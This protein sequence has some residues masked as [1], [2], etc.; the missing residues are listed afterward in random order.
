L[1]SIGSVARVIAFG[2]LLALAV[3]TPVFSQ[4]AFALDTVV[5]QAK[6]RAQLLQD[7]PAAIST[8]TAK[9]L[10]VAGINDVDDVAEHVPV[11]DLQ[12]S[13]SV[14]T[15]SFRIRRVGNLGNIPTFEPAVG[16]FVDGAF[17]SRSFLAGDLLNV[18]RVEV[19]SGPQ[20]TLYGKNASA[21]VVAI[22]T[23]EPAPEPLVEG[24]LS[25]GLF[26]LE[27]SASVR[28][29]R[30][31][32]SGP[33]SD[34]WR[35]SIAA[36]KSRHGATAT[37][38]M[39]GAP[40]G[41][42]Q[43]RL[44]LRGQLMWSPSSEL[45]LRLIAGYVEERDNQGQPDVYL[46]PGAPST[47]VI[48]TLQQ[49]GLAASCPENVPRNRVS[50]A[51]TADTLDLDAFDITM[52][53]EYR[54]VN[55]WKLTSVTAWDHYET[56]RDQDDV[57]QLLAP[58]LFFH[59]SDEGTSAQQELRLI[60]ADDARV[61]WL[62]GAFYYRNDY[63]RG[64]HGDRP[65]FGANG[66]LAFDPLWQALLGVPLA[67]PNQLGMHDSHLGT[68]YLG[69]FAEATWSLNSR[70][71]IAGGVRWHEEEKEGSI[72]NSLSLPG[73]SIIS[74]ALTPGVAPD[75]EPVN[76]SVNRRRDNVAWSTTPQYRFDEH[77]TAYATVARGWKSGGFNTGFGNAP[78]SAREFDDESV[79][80]YELGAKIE[81]TRVR[82]GAAAF[83]TE[84]RNYQDAA[85]RSVQ[86]T[87]GNAERVELQGFEIEGK[88]ALHERITGDFAISRAD[89]RYATHTTGLCYPGRTP[90]GSDPGSC[91]LSGEHPIDAPEWQTHVGLEYAVPVRTG[92][93][94][95]RV[96]WSWTD[97]YNTSFSADPRLVQKAY[98]DVGLRLGA[99]V[100]GS[101]EVVLW[102]DNLLGETVSYVDGVLNLFN[103]ASYQSFLAVAR[104]YGVTVRA[105]F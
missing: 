60:S 43:N 90:D 28:Q 93:I 13:N 16:L 19:L 38:A 4:D 58:A 98:S 46:S 92:E 35:A 95:A 102:G 41:D 80:H 57:S 69:L 37:N 83:H 63:N 24:E 7:V 84:Y 5:V 26:N 10:S 50:C 68:R 67:L 94:F 70:F 48:N 52:L 100:A 53:A 49:Q 66:E 87:V 44:A 64:S 27:D 32:A 11:F 29:M 104:S 105:R 79:R 40:D 99:R 23:K 31:A 12:R 75:G 14:T 25:L 85:F 3:S 34:T 77:F 15:T 22:Y 59:D 82:I 72:H 96:D 76:G 89:L 2:A 74:I 88:A 30:L 18:E 47:T 42:D 91:N 54:L 9:D 56:R 86:F 39:A 33:L 78:L 55:G 45:D 62:G 51:L 81:W 61:K 71:S 36:G 103:D 101:Y 97:D 17:R 65:M 73:A 20:T 8:L 21:G 6:K 1:V